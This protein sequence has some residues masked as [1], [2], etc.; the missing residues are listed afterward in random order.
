MIVHLRCGGMAA[1]L[2][3]VALPGCRPAEV[4]RFT[5]SAQ[6]VALTDDLDAEELPVYREL[7]KQIADTLAA[8]C[9][10]A[11]APKMLGET[12]P[13][14]ARLNQLENGFRVFSRYCVQCHGVN[15]DGQGEIAHYLKPRPRDY[16]QGIFK[17]ISTSNGKARKAD[18]VRTLRRGVPGTSMP[19][20]ATLSNSDLSDVADY[21]LALTT[22]G[23]LQ[24]ILA[25][26]AFDDG[27]LPDDAG[28]NDI[29]QEVLAPWQEANA[30][31]VMPPPMPP[32]T[33]ETIEEGHQIFL[34]LACSRCHGNDG[35]GGTQGVEVGTDVWGYKAAAAD[36]TS[37]MFH[38][39][40][41]PIDIYRRI[42][43][44]IAGSPMPA[45]SGEFADNPDDIWRLVHFIKDTGQR[46]RRHQAPLPAPPAPAV[47]ATAAPEATDTADDPASVDP[48]DDAPTTS[49]PE[50]A[51]PPSDDGA[52]ADPPAE[53]G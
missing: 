40:G 43:A 5:P 26:V 47:P 42:Y 49:P 10:Q 33:A 12:D 28:I 31:V 20:F 48:A 50:D 52:A 7:Q 8:R 6:V 32:M 30:A 4:P 9:G 37:G 15:G 13:G 3:V 18:L 45:F 17:F 35:R 1:L 29:V 25:Q 46:R 41:R 51:P 39:G 38:G 44:G 53:A 11:H 27:E 14:P 22:R 36:L 34:K 16:T 21:V 2:A 19:S 24:R 23:E